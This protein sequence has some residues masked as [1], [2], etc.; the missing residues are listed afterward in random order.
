MPTASV[1]VR[2]VATSTY[3]LT[4]NSRRSEDG[5]PILTDFAQ[6]GDYTVTAAAYGGE[7]GDSTFDLAVPAPVEPVTPPASDDAKKSGKPGA[8]TSR[9]GSEAGLGRGTGTPATR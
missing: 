2:N 6:P 7:P 5:C 8:N 3:D 4:W 9:A 1:V